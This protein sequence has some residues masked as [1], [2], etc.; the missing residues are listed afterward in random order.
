MGASVRRRPSRSRSAAVRTSGRSRGGRADGRR[1]WSR[2]CDLRQPAQRLPLP[3]SA[4]NIWR[5]VPGHDPMKYA[6]GLTNVTD[7]AFAKDGSLYAVQITDNGLTAPVDPNPGSVVRIPRAAA[8]P[9][10]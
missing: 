10:P 5:V 3:G 2:R 6:S 7:L 9:S 8:F 4:S 1:L